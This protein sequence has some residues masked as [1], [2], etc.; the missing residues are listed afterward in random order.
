MPVG[1]P[2]GFGK[3]PSGPASKCLDVDSGR[4]ANGT[5]IQSWSC[6]D[7]NV[8]QQFIYEDNQFKWKGNKKRCIDVHGGSNQNGTPLQMW[9]CDVNNR[10]Q[11]FLVKD[12]AGKIV[13]SPKSPT[14]PA[15]ITPPPQ[16]VKIDPS[17]QVTPSTP[18]GAS[19]QAQPATQESSG[20]NT[21]LIIGIGAGVCCLLI[22]IVILL[23]MKKRQ[24]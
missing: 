20:D 9:D 1:G 6:I 15:P 22:L 17:I 2:L 3:L 24:N 16:V 21:T 13:D 19:V 7:G 10:N 12:A 14:P 4:N 11:K 23:M 8:N 5:K 18:T